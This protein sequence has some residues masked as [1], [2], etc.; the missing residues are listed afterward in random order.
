MGKN[1]GYQDMS[2]KDT[3]GVVTLIMGIV[4]L[5]GCWIPFLNII[6]MIIAISGLIIGICSIVKFLKKKCRNCALAIIGMILSVITICLG[7]SINNSISDTFNK[8]SKP[9]SSNSSESNNNEFKVGDVIS[10]DDKE[11]TVTN[12]TRNYNTG[13]QF[14]KPK[15]GKEFVKVTVEIKNK[16]KS[17]ISY[18]TFD[19]KIKNSDGALQDAEAET[20]SLSDS[21]SSGQLSENGKI[22]GSMVFEVPKGDKNLSLKYS[23]SF[24]SNKNIEI[25][26]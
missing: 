25:K 8:D 18:N 9:I 5:I 4:A 13:N 16:S 12:L 23:P 14:S 2:D 22:K 6:S 20:Y 19:F 7:F 26:L 10:F 15:D 11:V 3:F 21:L 24:W 1:S 17:D